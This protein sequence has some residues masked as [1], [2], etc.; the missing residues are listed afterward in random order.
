MHRRKAIAQS[1]A[2]E[3]SE[4]LLT[5]QRPVECSDLQ[6]VS[7]ESGSLISSRASE[8]SA[9]SHKA[10]LIDVKV[11]RKPSFM[12]Q[13]RLHRKTMFREPA[14]VVSQMSI[15][16]QNSGQKMLESEL[17]PPESLQNVLTDK[18]KAAAYQ[19]LIDQAVAL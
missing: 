5:G 13:P 2:E 14:L 11:S 15:R 18:L 7:S 6:V 1:E 3:V 8:Q 9:I 19:N 10:K 17:Q 16:R 4:H 12:V